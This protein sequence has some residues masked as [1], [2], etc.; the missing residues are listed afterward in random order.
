MA[1]PSVITIT[2]NEGLTSGQGFVDILGNGFQLPPAVNVIGPAQPAN[3]SVRVT[4]NGKASPKVV[5]ISES[6]LLVQVPSSTL[7]ASGPNFGAGPVDVVIEN[8][9]QNGDLVPGETLTI[10]GGYTYTR[11]D[12][13]EESVLTSLV[14]QLIL[15]MKRQIISE[16]TLTTHTDYDADTADGLNI[17]E[18]AK[19]PTVIIAGPELEENRFYSRNI[20]EYVT[21]PNGETQLCQVGYTTDLQFDI[22]GVSD[23]TQELLNLMALSID[24]FHKNK[25]LE[26]TVGNE[27]VEYE[28]DFTVGGEPRMR[29]DA[30]NSNLRVFSGQFVIRGFVFS[31]DRV[32]DQTRELLGVPTLERGDAVF[33]TAPPG[34]TLSA[35]AI[36]E[37]VDSPQ[38]LGETFIVGVNPPDC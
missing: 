33:P 28:M 27:D 21:L 11:K 26:L 1:V 9:D 4:F 12:L 29:S 13:T 38:Q 20:Q 32:L 8:I 7:P 18:L 17:T 37:S 22:M 34:S 14:R 24:F 15:E 35:G 10:A 31:S 2:P 3:P 25:V 30:T 23:N 36:P 5:V 6:R 16:V 19:L